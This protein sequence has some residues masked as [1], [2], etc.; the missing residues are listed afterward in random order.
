VFHLI[1]PVALGRGFASWAASLHAARQTGHGA[2]P[3]VIAIDVK[4]VRGSKTAPDG[5]GALHLVSAYA[6]EAGLVLAQRAVD[7]KPNE[8]IAVPQLLELLALD[9][10]IVSID[11]IGTRTGPHERWR[12]TLSTRRTPAT[13][14]TKCRIR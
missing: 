4:T 10:A 6:S 12:L 11:A 1:D 3:E 14:G 2:S 13:P 5:T 8:I 9:R 7:A